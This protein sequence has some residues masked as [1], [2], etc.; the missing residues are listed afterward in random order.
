[1]YHCQPRSWRHEDIDKQATKQRQKDEAKEDLEMTLKEYWV[2]YF[3]G[4]SKTKTSVTSLVLQSPE[5]FLAE[6]ALKID[7]PTTNNEAEYEALITGIGLAKVLRVKNIKILGDSRLM[8]SQVN[9]D[10]EARKIFVKTLTYIL[11][12]GILYKKSFLIP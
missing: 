3:D 7:F 5:G 12:D 1:M 11:I 2:C 8:V 10:Y 4:A 6:Y 9:D